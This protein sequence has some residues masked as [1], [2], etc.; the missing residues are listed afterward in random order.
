MAALCLLPLAA[1]VSDDDTTA[2]TETIFDS[3]D[4]LDINGVVLAVG[5]LLVGALLAVAGYRLWQTTVY[6]L[7]FLGGGIVIAVIFERVFK[8]ETWVLTASWIAFVVGGV[9]CG[10]LCVYLYWVGLAMAGAVG[11]AALAIL[12]NTSFG[13]KFAPSHPGTVLIVL[14]VVFAVIGGGL[15]LWL[16]KPALVAATS[17]VGAFLLVWGIGYFA[18]NYPTFNDLSRFR[19]YN[20]SGDLVYSIPG[21][22]WAYLVGT[23][24]VFGLSM[25]LQFRFT[26]KDVDYHSMDRQYR[27]SED[28]LPRRGGPMGPVRVQYDNMG[29]PEVRPQHQQ[30]FQ[31]RYPTSNQVEWEDLQQNRPAP[32]RQTQQYPDNSMVQP[33]YQQREHAYQISDVLPTTTR[34]QTSDPSTSSARA[35]APEAPTHAY[36]SGY[37]KNETS[38]I[39]QTNAIPPNAATNARSR[40]L[41]AMTRANVV[42]PAIGRPPPT[43]ST[44]LLD[45]QDDVEREKATQFHTKH[46][47]FIAL[48]ALIWSWVLQAEASQALQSHFNKPFF[49]VCFNHA[50]PV[51]LLPLVFGYYRVCGSSADRHAGWDVVGVLQRHSVLPLAK[52]TRIAAFLGAFYLVADYFWYAAL[53]HVSVAAGTAIFNCSP[54]F[55]YCFS[56]CFLHETLSTSKLAGVLTSFVGVSLLVLFQDGSDLD[57]VESTSLVAGLL[58]I[59]SAA[60]YAA[61]QVAMRLAVGKDLTDTA[62]LLTMAGLC[63]LFTTPLWLLGSLLLTQSPFPSLYE[64]LELPETGEGVLLLLLSGALTVVFCAFLPLALCWTSPLE[65]SVGCMLTIPL[66]GLLDTFMHH[67]SFSWECI[68]GSVLVM[69]GFAILEYSTSSHTQ[70]GPKSSEQA[71]P[72]WA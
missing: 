17:L 20:T 30:P 64:S 2:T 27:G 57:A 1:A 15:T 61:Y 13:Y 16:Q 51:V 50:A 24:V 48:F 36:P 47:G 54:L 63:G 21:A 59:V 40:P 37:Q 35:T 56:V 33:Q 38:H 25:V 62:T 12:I 70:E 53:A 65:T 32:S 55:V 66:S 29:T 9:I 23:L 10:Y 67:T 43:E 6:A 8:D 41:Q 31:Q 22:W 49:L 5:A 4:G 72:S 42:A 3:S 28:V 52:L 19:T 69:T 68:V 46:A 11:G 26:G 58:M 7:G 14:V 44:K 34:P 60:L 71:S 39:V 45:P 18:G